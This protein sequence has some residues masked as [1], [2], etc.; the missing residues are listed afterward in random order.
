MPISHPA[1]SFCEV[2]TSMLICLY[3]LCHLQVRVITSGIPQSSENQLSDC[4][5]LS[6]LSSLL[7]WLLLWV[8]I[9]CT[10]VCCCTKCSCYIPEYRNVFSFSASGCLKLL[11]TLIQY[12]LPGSP[13]N[14]WIPTQHLNSS[15]IS[16]ENVLDFHLWCPTLGTNKCHVKVLF[17]FITCISC[18][19]HA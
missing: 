18:S 12:L 3:N 15:N 19:A 13:S 16:Y 10:W 11:L 14:S 7:V 6:H 2:L 1:T 17:S 9:P 5:T 8:L 4:L